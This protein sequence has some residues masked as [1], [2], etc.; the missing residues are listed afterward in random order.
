MQA[1]VR[2]HLN[3]AIST[4]VSDE[5]FLDETKRLTATAP[6]DLLRG[7]MQCATLDVEQATLIH[8]LLL[9]VPDLVN[10]P[11]KLNSTESLL[12]ECLRSE[13]SRKLPSSACEDAL[14]LLAALLT[15]QDANVRPLV[16]RNEMLDATFVPTLKRDDLSVA[17]AVIRVLL[18]GILQLLSGRPE[19][20]TV[21]QL[22]STSPSV[23]VQLRTT[24]LT[25]LLTVLLQQL[26][27]RAQHTPEVTELLLRATHGSVQ[28]L[29]P[30]VADETDAL[31]D[32]AWRAAWRELSWRTQLHAWPLFDRLSVANL[33]GAPPAEDRARPGSPGERLMRWIREQAMPSTAVEEL[34]CLVAAASVPGVPVRQALPLV[35]D[36]MRQPSAETPALQPESRLSP[37]AVHHSVYVALGVGLSQCGARE[38]QHAVSKLTPAMATSGLLLDPVT[39]GDLVHCAANDEESHSPITPMPSAEPERIAV[40][41]AHCLLLSMRSLHIASQGLPGGERPLRAFAQ[42]FAKWLTSA[43]KA[44]TEAL[45]V[46]HFLGVALRSLTVVPHSSVEP[47]FMLVLAAQRRL[48]DLAPRGAIATADGLA[49]N[50][51][52]DQQMSRGARGCHERCVDALARSLSSAAGRTTTAM[53]D[54]AFVPIEELFHGA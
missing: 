9:E 19:L 22:P 42:G 4:S 44:A 5:A 40:R 21:Q 27:R 30:R 36:R 31:G 20:L 48:Q 53:A 46:A 6:S 11:A 15:M 54:A 28:L 39:P 10:T 51:A 33:H 49:C 25:T 37:A 47:Y 29:L 35:L 45:S 3:R 1:A 12:M 16:C 18:R 2:R 17:P 26:E 41:S 50:A 23:E 8:R 32:S 52:A 38:W 24:S 34:C 13:F 14:L 7:C 43:L